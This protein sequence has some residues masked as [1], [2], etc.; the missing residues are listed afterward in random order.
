MVGQAYTLS[1]CEV[2]E[3]RS[4]AQ[5]HLQLH[6]KFKTSPRPVRPYLQRTTKSTT[7]LTAISAIPASRLR[8]NSTFTEPECHACFP[9][10]SGNT[11]LVHVNL[12][13]GGSSAAST[14]SHSLGTTKNH[15]C[16]TNRKDR[17][18]GESFSGLS[19]SE[20]RHMPPLLTQD[21]NEANT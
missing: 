11:L 19:H 8:L 21:P 18:K 12:K 3:G 4:R 10:L 5:G 17:K 2:K 13:L 9:W 20:D 1:P 15:G 14:V 16:P 7:V 6:I